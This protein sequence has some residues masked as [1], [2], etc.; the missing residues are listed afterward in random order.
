LGFGLRQVL[1]EKRGVFRQGRFLNHVFQASHT[2]RF[3]CDSVVEV[4][5]DSLA[6]E[7]GQLSGSGS[8]G[9]SFNNRGSHGFGFLRLIIFLDG[10]FH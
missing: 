6:N 10:N 4:T 1:L 9:G 3:E 8:S 5:V 2:C 7:F